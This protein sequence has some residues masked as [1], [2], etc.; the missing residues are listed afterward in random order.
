MAAFHSYSI[1]LGLGISL[2]LAACGGSGTEGDGTGT[3]SLAT[4]QPTKDS[5]IIGIGGKLFS[6]PSPAQTALA[7]RKAG[8]KYQKDLTAPLEKGGTLTTKVAQSL[9]LGV[10]GADLAYVTVHKD[11]ARAMATMQ[12]IEKL[13]GQLGVTNAFD[14]T[15]L[16]RFKSSMNNEDSL[17]RLSGTAFRAA[18]QYLK[19][20]ES[21]DVSALVLA[22]GWV[23]SLYLTVSDAAALKDQAMVNRI[24]E[25]KSTLDAL[26][27][28]IEASDKEGM[29]AEML[30]AMK[31]LQA[32][33]S[34]VTSTY[35]FAEPVTDA[36]AKTTFINSTTQVSIPAEKVATITAKVTAIRNMILA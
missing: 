30:K 11:G 21:E 13:G 7:M 4:E 3:D 16:D 27:Q 28:L 1:T 24:G 32:E 10:Y 29:A 25:Q 34:A 23:E 8:L 36:A 35:T 26:V 2:L 14:R 31:D 15:L 20:N 12:A 18:D 19:M 6:I 5:E 17:L 9:A 22:G 33:F